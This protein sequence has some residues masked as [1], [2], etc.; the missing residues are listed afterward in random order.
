VRALWTDPARS[1]T[2][3]G[4]WMVH[5]FRDVIFFHG[6]YGKVSAAASTQYAITRWHPRLIVNLGTC[7]GFGPTRKV[8]DVVLASQTIIYDIVEQMGDP[9]ETIHDYSTT[10]DNTAW[11]ARLRDRVDRAQEPSARVDPASGHRCRRRGWA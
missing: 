3:Y 9:D 7:G 8:G 11:P 4:E 5:R 6:G 2:P 1:D 10:L